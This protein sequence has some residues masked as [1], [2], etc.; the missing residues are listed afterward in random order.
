MS[1]VAGGTACQRDVVLRPAAR[2][3]ALMAVLLSNFASRDVSFECRGVDVSGWAGLRRP[4][5]WVG[6]RRL[7]Q[8]QEWRRDQGQGWPPRL[9]S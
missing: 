6:G 8:G 7:P 4:A 1:N 9:F 2:S 5:A 3:S